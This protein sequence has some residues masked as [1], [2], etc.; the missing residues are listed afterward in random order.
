MSFTKLATVIGASSSYN[1]KG[2]TSLFCHYDFSSNHIH[3]P[4]YIDFL[5]CEQQH[6]PAVDKT[7]APTRKDLIAEDPVI[8]MPRKDLHKCA[9]AAMQRDFRTIRIDMQPIDD[10]RLQL[11]PP[12]HTKADDLRL[13]HDRQIAPFEVGAAQPALFGARID[14]KQTA[15][16]ICFPN[17]ERRKAA[18]DQVG[19]IEAIA[20]F[21]RP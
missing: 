1:S 3:P 21:L 10:R 17:D 5:S 4:I 15:R 9:D 6:V 16:P 12:M 18:R 2:M 20:V 8:R 7:N 11:F 19:M 13:A 14:A